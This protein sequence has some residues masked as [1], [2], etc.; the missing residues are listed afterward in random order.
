MRLRDRRVLPLTDREPDMDFNYL[1]HRHGVS[2]LRAEHA[3]CAESRK[4]HRGLAAAYADRIAAALR[5]QP[6]AAAA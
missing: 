3:A 5:R 4:A 2:L 6:C 1:Y